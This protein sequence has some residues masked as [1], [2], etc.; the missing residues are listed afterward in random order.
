MSVERSLEEEEAFN[1]FIAARTGDAETLALMISRGLTKVNPTDANNL[2]PLSIAVQKGHE[3][4]VR[5]LLGCG[6]DT[7][8]KDKSGE[9]T[10]LH[11]A[12]SEGATSMV[13]LL[14]AA[15]A[16]PNAFDNVKDTPLN[17]AVR[18]G[19]VP[20]S[21][22]LIESKASV[23]AKSHGG[24]TALSIAQR[25]N[26]KEMLAL[27]EAEAKVEASEVEPRVKPAPKAGASS[28]SAAENGR[29]VDV[30]DAAVVG[31]SSSSN[32]GGAAAN[33]DDPSATE[34][35]LPP[36]LVDA[37]NPVLTSERKSHGSV[38]FTAGDAVTLQLLKAKPEL[39]GQRA[40]VLGL[41]AASGRYKVRLSCAAADGGATVATSSS[42]CIK[43]L[44][45]PECMLP[46]LDDEAESGTYRSNY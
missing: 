11:H 2:T 6:A 21:R 14:V 30:S 18:G 12:A 1:L 23:L 10:A 24:S 33:D 16:N 7:E 27:V 5:L 44:V 45:K 43:V 28:A 17:E 19:H 34:G 46:V 8:I 9:W 42:S 3:E 4:A 22:L 35:A 13:A 20:S 39:N 40:T 29:A 38:A 26:E 25:R 31:S 36:P 41:D 15:G 32:N 37:A